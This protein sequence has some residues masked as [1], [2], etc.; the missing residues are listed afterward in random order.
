MI[1]EFLTRLVARVQV[2]GIRIAFRPYGNAADCS[3]EAD[4]LPERTAEWSTFHSSEGTGEVAL[5]I[6]VVAGRRSD[7]EHFRREVVIDTFDRVYGRKK[8]R[9]FPYCPIAQDSFYCC[10]RDLRANIACARRQTPQQQRLCL[11]AGWRMPCL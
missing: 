2:P 9:A 10:L 4:P 3:Y 1:F 6:N 8:K 11:T 7:L 5:M